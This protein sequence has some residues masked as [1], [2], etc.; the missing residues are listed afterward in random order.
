MKEYVVKYDSEILGNGL[1]IMT[2]NEISDYNKCAL[3]LSDMVDKDNLPHTS[4]M[5]TVSSTNNTPSR[6]QKDS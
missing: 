5:W 3:I 1:H 6:I 4:G 2:K